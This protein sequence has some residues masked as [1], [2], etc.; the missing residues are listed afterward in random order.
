[1]KA[2]E[3][4]P[5]IKSFELDVVISLLIVIII[6]MSIGKGINVYIYSNENEWLNKNSLTNI[7]VQGSEI[8]LFNG[9]W[10]NEALLEE[11]SIE[12]LEGRGFRDKDFSFNSTEDSI[13]V[14]LGSSFKECFKLGDKI[15]YKDYNYG[16]IERELE[17]IGF[18]N[19]DQYLI[20]K[21]I[22]I[23]N[24]ENLNYTI[25]LPNIPI[26]TEIVDITDSK[27]IETIN[28]NL[29]KN[30]TESYLILDNDSDINDIKKKSDEMNFFDIEVMGSN[31]SSRIIEN[32]FRD[33]QRI[34]ISILLMIL[35][36]SIIGIISSIILSINK[37]RSEFSIYYALGFSKRYIL[38]L[39][40][41]EQS[42]YFISGI[43]A[44]VIFISI[45]K[46]IGIIGQLNIKVVCI[47]IM[48]FLLI[49]IISNI[50]LWLY[51]KKRSMLFIKR[52]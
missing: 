50:C 32:Y 22:M 12:I 38:A 17:V 9:Y 34:N 7:E 3:A 46:S 47:S 6:F 43:I 33:E 21:P 10:V 5:C 35:I 1:M 20:K 24:T 27:V 29:Y 23:S 14:I 8:S 31:E 41:L 18:L 37:R 45:F 42:V 36:S 52:R 13:P 28:I 40:I 4:I 49:M 19:K 51:S 16:G 39:L 2:T 11:L 44:S 30:I 15:K 48:F 26:N 25:L